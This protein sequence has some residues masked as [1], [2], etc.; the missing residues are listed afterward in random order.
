M[1]SV[2]RS[3]KP[4]ELLKMLGVTAKDRFKLE[5]AISKTNVTTR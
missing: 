4:E 1:F 2:E 3:N 5:N